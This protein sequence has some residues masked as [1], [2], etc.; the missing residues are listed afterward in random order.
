MPF[1]AIGPVSRLPARSSPNPSD[2]AASL[3]S[4]S[5]CSRWLAA[6]PP[7]TVLYVSFGTYAPL[8][9]SDLQEIAMGIITS[10]VPFLWALRSDILQ[11]NATPD[12]LPPEFYEYIKDEKGL[13]VEW[14]GQSSVLS[15][16]AVGGFLTHC[17]WNSVMESFWCGVPM[18]C[19]PLLTDQFTNRKL[20][21]DEWKVGVS[22]GRPGAVRREAV[23]EA[24]GKVMRGK[25]GKEMRRRIEKRSRVL[26]EAVA[27]GGSSAKSLERFAHD[28]KNHL[29]ESLSTLPL[30]FYSLSHSLPLPHSLLSY[31]SESLHDLN[32]NPYES[33]REPATR[34][35]EDWGV[36]QGIS[37]SKKLLADSSSD[38]NVIPVASP[39]IPISTANNANTENQTVVAKRSQV[40]A[41]PKKVNLVVALLRGMR[42]EDVLLQLQVKMKRAAKTVYQVIN[43]AR[44][45]ATHNHGLDP[46][47]LLLAEAFV[48]K[49]FAFEPNSVPDLISEDEAAKLDAILKSGVTLL[50][51]DKAEKLDVILNSGDN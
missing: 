46:E 18:L 15:H 22:V 24:V 42:V 34:G 19:L 5:D 38:T 12:P 9:Q 32:S 30:S 13:V 7:G 23:V 36:N 44:A 10:N 1:Y 47:R 2:P 37:T 3:R 35:S 39:L 29:Q 25:E 11:G 48:G 28:L 51:K 40:Q 31:I 26:H 14:C 50:V 49:G 21:V 4:E 8:A 16:P 27:D 17:G 43:S 45:N 20:V 41:S 6:K 33:R